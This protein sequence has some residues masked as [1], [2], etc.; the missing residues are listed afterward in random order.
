MKLS[1]NMDKMGTLIAA[2]FIDEII[3]IALEKKRS[4]IECRNS[5][6]SSA[7]REEIEGWISELDSILIQCSECHQFNRARIMG[8]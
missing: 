7:L 3:S 2:K 8:E 5:L 1:I 4:C 6:D